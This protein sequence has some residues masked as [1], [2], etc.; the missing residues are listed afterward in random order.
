[1]RITVAE[2]MQME[3]LK[4]ATLVAGKNGRHRLIK[5]VNIMEVPDIKRFIKR[6]ELLVTTTYPIRTDKDAQETLIPT[7]VKHGVA[8][9]AIKPVFYDNAVPKL[10][11][12]QANEADFPIICLP[13][14][15]SFNDILN[16]VLGEILNRQTRILQRN[17]EIHQKFTDIVLGGGSI[18]EVAHMLAVILETPVSVHS[19]SWRLLAFDGGELAG[20]DW[21]E[22]ASDLAGQ[23]DYL[24]RLAANRRGRF[25]VDNQGSALEFLAHPVTVAREDYAI[26]GIWLQPG[27]ECELNVIEQAATIVALE[28]AKLRAVNEVERRFRSHFMEELV[29]GRLASKTEVLSRGEK[30]G[31]DLSGGFVPLLIEIDDFDTLIQGTHQSARILGNLRGLVSEAIKSYAPGSIG[32]EMGTRMLV[33]TKPASDSP[34]QQIMDLILKMQQGLKD[35][36]TIS[37]GVGRQAEDVMVLKGSYK[38]ASQALEL[39]KMIKGSGRITFFDDLGAYRLLASNRKNPELERFATELLGELSLH[40]DLIKTLSALLSHNGNLREA[41]RSMY[42]HYNTLRYRV[43]KIQ[44]ITG[45]DLGTSEGR[46][47]LQLALMIKQ[48]N[49]K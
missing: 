47:N 42:V 46:L 36:V 29:F 8:A 49:R 7:L 11:I 34:K 10:M 20:Y 32:V 3:A 5:S 45:E 21:V 12:E 38:Q 1:M 2:A 19:T 22:L 13:R 26:L 16:P 41:S 43:N 33:L 14:D 9:L 4:N 23:P 24:Q 15:A 18:C 31:W 27:A 40:D 48:L 6:D 17:E 25:K 37:A 39:G 35:N 28:T 44:E 30:Y